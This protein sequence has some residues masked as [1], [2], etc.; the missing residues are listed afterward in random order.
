MERPDR[1]LHQEPGDQCDEQRVLHFQP[2]REFLG[3]PTQTQRVRIEQSLLHVPHEVRHRE[4]VLPGERVRIREHDA[5]DSHEREQAAGQGVEEELAG[6]VAAARA[7]APPRDQEERGDQREFEERIEE[8]H[9][10]GEERTD[11]PT[12]KQEEP[13][14]IRAGS[15]RDRIPRHENCREHHDAAEDDEPEVEAVDAEEE[16][17]VGAGAVQR[18]SRAGFVGRRVGQAQKRELRAVGGAIGGATTNREV[19]SMNDDATPIELH[20]AGHRI[21]WRQAGE[22]LAVPLRPAREDTRLLECTFVS[23]QVEPFAHGEFATAPVEGDGVRPAHF[24][25]HLL[26]ALQLIDIGLPGHVVLLVCGWNAR[27]ACP[28][29]VPTLRQA[30]PWSNRVHRPPGASSRSMARSRR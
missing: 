9:V 19:A 13:A 28:S 27:S 30:R 22:A 16:L 8:D 25:R 21:C 1:H 6:G 20:H 23:E 14:V 17:D 11:G 4:R 3:V 24:V 12:L 18:C 2:V 5:D 15:I 29:W 7:V 26:A 10:E